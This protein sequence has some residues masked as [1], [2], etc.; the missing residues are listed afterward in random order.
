ML[1]KLQCVEM[2]P[3][4]DILRY[5]WV[6]RNVQSNRGHMSKKWSGFKVRRLH[7]VNGDR[8]CRRYGKSE[9][10]PR[11]IVNYA[12]SMSQTSV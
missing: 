1:I 11:N 12:I 8:Q 6:F 5:H 7:G 9:L 2:L 4:G 10:P 3:L